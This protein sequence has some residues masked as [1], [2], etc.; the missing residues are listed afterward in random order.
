MTPVVDYVRCYL[1]V[2]LRVF[3]DVLVVISVISVVI[4]Y[5]RVF[6]YLV[7]VVTAMLVLFS[8]TYFTIYSIVLSAGFNTFCS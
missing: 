7:H 6:G 4:L 5:I 8:S 1:V 3:T 2:Q